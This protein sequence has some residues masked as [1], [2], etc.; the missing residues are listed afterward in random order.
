MVIC[1]KNK[2]VFIELKRSKKSL[3]KVSPEQV[4]WINILNT[5]PHCEARVC[6]GFDDAKNFIS[7]IIKTE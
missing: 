3:S 1:L 2:L 7:G 4:E 6:Y 5:Y